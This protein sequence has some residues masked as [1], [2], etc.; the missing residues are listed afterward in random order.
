MFAKNPP[1]AVVAGESLS[2]DQTCVHEV[3]VTGPAE[4]DGNDLLFPI[5][6]IQIE[7]LFLRA[8]SYCSVCRHAVN[9]TVFVDGFSTTAAFR[10][11]YFSLSNGNFE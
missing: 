7:N 9:L 8:S 2:E 6:I 4:I 1:N 3:E 10:P 11:L 5:K